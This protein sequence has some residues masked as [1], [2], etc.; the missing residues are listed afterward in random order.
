MQRR[1]VFLLVLIFLAAAMGFAQ[2][3]SRYNSYDNVTEIF[4]SSGNLTSA[5][6]TSTLEG[7][8]SWNG[9]PPCHH[10]GTVTVDFGGVYSSASVGP[11]WPNY[12]MDKSTYVT[13]PGTATCFTSGGCQVSQDNANVDCECNGPFYSGAG[14]L[15]GETVP[16]VAISLRDQSGQGVFGDDAGR[17]SYVQNVNSTGGLGFFLQT[18]GNVFPEKCAV[19][20][21]FVGTVFPSSYTQ[22][23]QL[24]REVINEGCYYGITP[25]AC[26]DKTTPYDDTSVPQLYDWNPHSCGP[27]VGACSAGKVYDVDAPG[28]DPYNNTAALRMRVNFREYATLDDGVTP[29]SPNLYF[30]VRMSCLTDSAGQHNNFNMDYSSQ[31]DNQISIGGCTPTT[32]DLSGS[33]SW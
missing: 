6:V 17:T 21:E 20:A 2:M 26:S 29:V 5:T 25:T 23:I 7:N 13:L 16:K 19:G 8:T 15:D 10:T 3:T 33:C 14:Q 22:N 32:A 28:L 11:V 9:Y 31:G 27:T 1:L 12:Y 24:H 4:D 18:L 30:Y